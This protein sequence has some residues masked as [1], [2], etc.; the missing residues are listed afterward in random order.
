MTADSGRSLL[1]EKGSEG[2]QAK[3]CGV[4]SQEAE[5]ADLDDAC[6]AF[7]PLNDENF[8]IEHRKAG[9]RTGFGCKYT[10]LGVLIALLAGECSGIRRKFV[11]WGY[12]LS[13]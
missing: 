2:S 7:A 13:A 8:D 9:L 12:S 4:K 6:S 11:A 1:A 3:S 5:K 10:S